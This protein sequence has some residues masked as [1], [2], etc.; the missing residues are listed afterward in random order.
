MQGKVHVSGA[1]AG[2]YIRTLSK[3]ALCGNTRRERER[4]LSAIIGNT[5]SPGLRSYPS[6]HVLR[7]PCP[8]RGLAPLRQVLSV[9][10]GDSC[11]VHRP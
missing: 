3:R 7:H 4:N 2:L 6:S 8:D 9:S 11:A 10:S 5:P 1:P